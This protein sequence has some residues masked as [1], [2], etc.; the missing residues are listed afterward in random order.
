[1]PSLESR[2]QNQRSQ[3]SLMDE[4]FAQFMSS[5]NLPHLTHVLGNELRMLDL[6]VKQLQVGYLDTILLSP[7]DG[8]VTGIFKGRGDRVRR[9]DVAVRVENNHSVYLVGTLVHRGP[10]AAATR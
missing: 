4:S 8:I 9:G 5:L 3:I 10:P 2:A 6:G 7:I 1:M